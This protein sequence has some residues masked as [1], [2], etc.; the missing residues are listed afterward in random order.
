LYFT[1][2]GENV[3]QHL[4]QALAIGA[5]V[6]AR[7][8]A[9]LARRSILRAAARGPDEIE[10]F[11][12]RVEC[13]H[14]LGREMEASGLDAGDVEHLVMRWSRCRPALRMWSALSCCLRRG[15]Q[16]EQ[17]ADTEDGV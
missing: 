14:R 2:V 10:R 3:E 6:Q 1:R 7:I 5:D 11:L 4:L 8:A 15:L 9:S 13:A 17:L 16:L 12:N